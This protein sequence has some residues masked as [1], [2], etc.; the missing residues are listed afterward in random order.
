MLAFCQVIRGTGVPTALA[1]RTTGS[2]SL[3]L[4]VVNLS[5][6]LGATTNSFSITFNLH[7]NREK[8]R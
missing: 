4:T 3:T 2:P 6:N 7:C 1:L 8:N 5:T